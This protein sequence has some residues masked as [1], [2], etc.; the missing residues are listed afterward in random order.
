MK[1]IFYI[2]IVAI[3]VDLLYSN[4][5]YYISSYVWKHVNDKGVLYGDFIV[6]DDSIYK[7]NCTQITY[8][9]RGNNGAVAGRYLLCF[10]FGFESR[11]WIYSEVDGSIG[12][13]RNI[14]P[15]KNGS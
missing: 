10:N 15:K 14:I 4:S 12:I 7:R 5:N 9:G 1:R 8:Y 6:F 13:Y 3:I 11:L 2:L